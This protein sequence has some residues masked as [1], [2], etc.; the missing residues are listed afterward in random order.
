M[1]CGGSRVAPL[2]K[3]LRLFR[4]VPLKVKRRGVEMRL[5]INGGYE[6]RKPNPALLKA[7]ASRDRMVRGIGI[8]P[9][10][11][12]CRDCASRRVAKAVRHAPDETDLRIAGFR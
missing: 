1:P 10:P 5:T 9:R 3:V 6:P 7:F 11:F 8:R 12:A 2:R 4:F